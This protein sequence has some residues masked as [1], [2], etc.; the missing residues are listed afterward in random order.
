MQDRYAG[1]VGD[2]GKF[3]LLRH[4]CGETAQDTHPRLKPGVIWYRANP[5]RGEKEKPDGKFV[6]Y[7][8]TPVKSPRLY[9][10][11]DEVVFKALA[12]VVAKERTIASLERKQ[13]FKDAVYWRDDVRHGRK[14]VTCPRADWFRCAS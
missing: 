8:Q 7:L 1:D 2:F 12:D 5:G 3:G 10:E 13:V 6:N 4:L 9:M 11:C 14:K